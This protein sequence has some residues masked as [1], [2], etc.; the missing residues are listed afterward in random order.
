MR[1]VL[2]VLLLVVTA[3]AER[4]S[5]YSNDDDHGRQNRNYG[6][7]R[8]RD[9]YHNGRNEDKHEKKSKRRFLKLA[10]VGVQ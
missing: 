5:F 7:G 6:R 4:G 9:D 10:R 8:N 2:G 3:F 1:L